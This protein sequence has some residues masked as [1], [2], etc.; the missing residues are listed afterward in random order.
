MI[1]LQTPSSPKQHLPWHLRWRA[2]PLSVDSLHLQTSVQPQT[3]SSYTCQNTGALQILKCKLRCRTS[4]ANLGIYIFPESHSSSKLYWIY[5]WF[6]LNQRRQIQNWWTWDLP[7]LSNS[8]QVTTWIQ[9]SNLLTI[10]FGLQSLIY[11]KGYWVHRTYCFDFPDG[12][13]WWDE[14][15]LLKIITDSTPWDMRCSGLTRIISPGVV[16]IQ[17]PLYSS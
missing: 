13:F 9:R 15:L 3:S 7:I 6:Y 17:I 14:L 4:S 2:P 11:T 1:F 16:D 8:L 10:E 12:D 5:H